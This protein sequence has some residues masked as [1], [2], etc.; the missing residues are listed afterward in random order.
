MKVAVI[1]G[2]RGLG[3]WIASFLKKKDC[4][5]VITGRDS[6]TGETEA[7]KIEVSYTSNNK[8]AAANSDV[9]IIAVPIE[10]TDDTINEVAPVMKNGALLVD[11][12]SVKE[13][14]A[15]LMQ[16]LSPKGVSVLPTHPMFGPR[17]RNLDGQVIVLT[18]MEDNNWTEKVIKFLEGEKA[19]VVITSPETHD[20]MMSVVQ[21]MTHFAYISIAATLEKL[22]VD[23]K[24]SRKFSSPIYSLML[25]MIAR[26]V[27]QNPY[28]CYSIQTDNRYI[29]E[30]HDIFL[31]TFIEL[32]DM[33]SEENREGFVNSM[34][35][36]AKHLGDL[37]SA[38]GRSDKAISALNAEVSILKRS[39]G[40]EVGLRHIYSG[41]THIG[42]LKDLT[43]DFL[44]LIEGRKET[45][46]K[47]SNVEILDDNEILKWKL[48]NLPIHFFDVSAM[49]PKSCDPE[50]IA[51]SLR[52]IEG[53]VS[54]EVLD[55]YTGEQISS[56]SK[57]VTIRYRVFDSQRSNDVE[58]LLKGF[59]AVIR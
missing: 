34:S 26:I 59:G 14:P 36:A 57:S 52:F 17:V 2:T 18:P 23:V 12:T 50:I 29:E 6:F 21:G 20:R 10:V 3:N 15:Q 45:K 58:N 5:V 55:V 19:R 37:E 25:D 48:E 11:V 43:P 39:L 42:I 16:E 28:L 1:G 47:L 7:S 8:D 24:E 35:N 49:F 4:D 40:K 56:D 22:E 31:K 38:L 54:S 9:V 41:R 44:L 32:K 53:V 30:T 33:I 46:L 51:D 27:A 13:R